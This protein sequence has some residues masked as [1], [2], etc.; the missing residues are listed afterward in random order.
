MVSISQ[1]Q[2]LQPQAK[3]TPTPKIDQQAVK[4]SPLIVRNFG[5]D[6]F[7]TETDKVCEYLRVYRVRR[8]YSDSDIVV[9][10]GYAECVSI[11]GV[12]LKSAV[13][14]RTEPSVGK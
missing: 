3:T 2:E 13:E 10:S 11:K 12:G 7:T 9:P 4:S 1:A 14:T 8:P 6:V 5:N